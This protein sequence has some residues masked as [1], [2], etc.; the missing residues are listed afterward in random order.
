[1]TGKNT[2]RKTTTNQKK[3]RRV[4]I[5]V[6]CLIVLLTILLICGTIFTVFMR[7]KTNPD[8]IARS[9]VAAFMAKDT[10]AL[11]HFLG[12]EETIFTNPDALARSLEEC[13]KYSTITSYGLTKY[14]DPSTPD[15]LQYKI[16]YWNNSHGNPYNQTLTL[17]KTGAKLYGFF[18]HWQI[19]QS[20]FFARNCTLRIPAGTTV[21][22]DDIALAQDQIRETTEQLTTYDLGNLFT[23]THTITVSAEGFQ[24]YT[25]NVYLQNKDY[26]GQPLYTITASMLDVTKDTEKKLAAQAEKMVKDLYAGALED[27]SFGDLH[28]KYPF[29][30]SMRTKLEQN[31]GTLINNHIHSA[32]RL[33]KVQFTGF[34]SS[35]SSAYAEDHCYAV[36]ITTNADY[37]TTSL[38]TSGNS[39]REKTTEGNS[40]FITIFH[41]RD[42]VWYIH[43]TTALTTCVYYAKNYNDR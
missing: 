19:D 9:Y 30:E 23:G 21:R 7:Q 8:S 11:F 3:K 12:M 33:T 29:E 20:E 4:P 37:H 39:S 25:T 26:G 10:S 1:M 18:D 28:K 14:A 27:K 41:Y 17:R 43:D 2:S 34:S 42:G 24:D 32:N 35:Y 38:V 13:H 31:Y 5:P 36:R 22:V 15:Q 16:E 40:L 6:K